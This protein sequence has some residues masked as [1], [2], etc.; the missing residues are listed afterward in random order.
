MPDSH[1]NASVPKT[2]QVIRYKEYLASDAWKIKR[3]EA[4]ERAN[5]RC[6]LCSETKRLNV[7]HNTYDRLGDE[8]PGDLITLC[9]RCHLVFHV[10]R[11]KRTSKKMIAKDPSLAELPKRIAA[12]PKLKVPNSPKKQKAW[13]TPTPI[14]DPIEVLVDREMIEKITTPKGG[15]YSSTLN[16]LGVVW[17]NGKLPP[18]K[19]RIFGK[20]ITVSAS[21][22]QEEIERNRPHD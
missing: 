14:L 7:H 8:L 6:Q 21:R 16:M 10:R 18:W 20:R 11:D 13:G 1:P 9:R 17:S 3:D 22:L 15:F 19:H 12:L 5:H 4:L 2:R